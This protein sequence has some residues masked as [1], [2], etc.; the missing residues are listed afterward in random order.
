MRAP[1]RPTWSNRRADH[2]KEAAQAASFFAVTH[3]ATCSGHRPLIYRRNERS[4]SRRR[5]KAAS[6]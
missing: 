4:M 1:N 6:V 5:A 2:V 3:A